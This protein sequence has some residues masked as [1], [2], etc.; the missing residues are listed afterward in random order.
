MPMLTRDL[1]KILLD[2]T[3]IIGARWSM[4]KIQA[5]NDILKVTDKF[6]SSA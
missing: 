4:L 3:Q 2:K 6:P 1:N 5:Q